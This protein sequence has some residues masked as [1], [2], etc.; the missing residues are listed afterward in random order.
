MKPK[1]TAL[2]ILIAAFAAMCLLT[3]CASTHTRAVT[4][5]PAPTVSTTALGQSIATGYSTATSARQRTETVIQTVDRII[6]KADPS[7]A[8][9]LR[10]VKVE[11]STVSADLQASKEAL[12]Q[13]ETERVETQKAVDALKTWGESQQAENMAN[14]SGWQQSEITS[15]E[16]Q[17]HVSKLQSIIGI[18]LG[19]GAGILGLKFFGPYGVAAGPV[20]FLLTYFLT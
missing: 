8:T 14:A 2:F 10:A 13:A 5:A 15:S 16:R 20:V 18:A 17:R 19:I 9:E 12:V 3:G 11:L 7:T 4:A 6:T 1:Y